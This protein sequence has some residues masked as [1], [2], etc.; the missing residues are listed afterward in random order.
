MKHV[1]G[2]A[3]PEVAPTTFICILFKTMMFL[4]CIEKWSHNIHIDTG[5][6]FRHIKTT[7]DT[8]LRWFQYRLIDRILPSRRLLFFMKV[9]NS[10]ICIYRVKDGTLEHLFWDCRKT[11]V[12]WSDFLDWL[13]TNFPHCRHLRMSQEL[14]IFGYNSKVHTDKILGLF[15][16]LGIP[17]QIK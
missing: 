15:I 7:Q 10:T 4:K 2:N 14:V 6:V 9:V 12:L 5:A 17:C 8:H 3:C 13:Y 11:Q 1:Y 16:L